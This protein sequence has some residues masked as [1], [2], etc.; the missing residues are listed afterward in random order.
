LTREEAVV[1]VGGTGRD[2]NGTAITA[3]TPMRVASVSKS[4][5]SAA[6]LT[7]LMN[8]RTVTWAQMTYLP[9]P[10][11]ATLG[12]AA[13]AGVATVLARVRWV[14]QPDEERSKAVSDTART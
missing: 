5:T 4:F 14:G 11:T 7:A 13:A 10:L 12:V 9:A 8:G 2:A 1:H 6:V 3:D